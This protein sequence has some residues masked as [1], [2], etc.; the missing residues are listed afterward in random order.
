MSNKTISL[1]NESERI[2]EEIYKHSDK[3][4][5]IQIQEWLKEEYKKLFEK[6]TLIKEIEEIES[7]ISEKQILLD[8]KKRRLQDI[9]QRE[10]EKLKAQQEQER[11]EQ[12]VH[13]Q[14]SIESNKRGFISRYGA[15]DE[16]A[17]RLAEEYV[18]IPIGERIGFAK[19]AEEVKG[20]KPIK[21]GEQR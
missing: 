5:S 3:K 20:L 9:K 17:Q 6:E 11:K 18:S 14:A 13:R 19:W 15:T 10:E 8:S 21:G 12:E 1:D 2:W 7:Y 16:E 4:F